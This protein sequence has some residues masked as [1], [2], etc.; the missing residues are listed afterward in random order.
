MYTN[1]YIFLFTYC[2]KTTKLDQFQIQN[3]FNK[4]LRRLIKIKSFFYFFFSL[5]CGK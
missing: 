4:K 3:K 2:D 5:R 1:V